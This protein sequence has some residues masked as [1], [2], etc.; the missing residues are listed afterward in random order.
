VFAV[1]LGVLIAVLVARIGSA[2][3]AGPDFASSADPG[4]EHAAAPATSMPTADMQQLEGMKPEMQ[5]ES[6]LELAIGETSGAVEQISSR[7]DGWRGQL[8]WNEQIATLTTAALN[9]RDMRVRESG[10]EIQLAAYGLGKNSLSLDYLLKTSESAEQSK[11]IWALWALGLMGNR[12]VAT[13]HVVQVLTGHLKD[14]DEESRRWAVEGL[15]L[16]GTNGTIAPLLKTMHDDP[17]PTVRE[18]AASGLAQSGMFTQVQRLAAV[19]QLLNYTDDP[20]LDA[21][22][23][24]WAFQALANITRQRL[25]NDSAAWRNWYESARTD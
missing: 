14:S 23:H 2:H 10:I 12:G 16:V 20:T 15:A 22:T 25:P 5:A 18:R 13:G 24:G 8:R 7:V 6:L 3:D 11:K 1:A 21:Q 17:S 9:S 4:A 19:P